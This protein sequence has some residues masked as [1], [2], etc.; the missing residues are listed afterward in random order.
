ML[1][2]FNIRQRN[3]VMNTKLSLLER[4]ELPRD[5]GSETK[6]VSDERWL[7]VP[8]LEEWPRTRG[9]GEIA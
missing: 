3:E 6:P 7:E 8:L 2:K 9:K 5:R 1:T 4:K